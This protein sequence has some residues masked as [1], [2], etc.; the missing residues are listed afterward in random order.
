MK[1]KEWIKQ[2]FCKHDYKLE[3]LDFCSHAIYLRCT[4]CN[5]IKQ[6]RKIL[7]KDKFYRSGKTDSIFAFLPDILRCKVN[8]LYN[9]QRH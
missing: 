4:K 1:F 3:K 2:L 5:K 7:N 6:I 9:I 8:K